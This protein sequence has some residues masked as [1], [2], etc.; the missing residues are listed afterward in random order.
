MA[1]SRRSF[2]K[3]GTAVSL[4]AAIP[5]R[6]NAQQGRGSIGSLETDPADLSFPTKAQFSEYLNT[7]FWITLGTWDTLEVELVAVND[8]K[9]SSAA[10]E[11]AT[12][13]RER[14]SL[15]FRGPKNTPLKQDTYTIKHHNLGTVMMFLVPMGKDKK[16][17]ALSYEA[18]VSRLSS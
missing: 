15:I 13:K 12:A 8:L 2:L 18:I 16:G 6:V 11:P 17:T 5:F 7:T 1:I 4:T 9:R 10:K 14:F 3:A